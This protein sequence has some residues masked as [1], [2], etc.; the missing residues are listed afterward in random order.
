MQ[1]F[2]SVGAEPPLM[3][4]MLVAQVGCGGLVALT[5][6]AAW[7][8]LMDGDSDYAKDDDESQKATPSGES[9]PAKRSRH[10]GPEAQRASRS[11]PEAHGPTSWVPKVLWSCE[12]M[13]SQRG[14]QKKNF[15]IMTLC[16]GTG[17]PLIA[18]KESQMTLNPTLPKERVKEETRRPDVC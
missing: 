18:L 14:R 4:S 8:I 11:L 17:S 16:S 7:E 6:K 13:R 10:E 3:K 5:M 2:T 9:H 15:E 1:G 12:Q